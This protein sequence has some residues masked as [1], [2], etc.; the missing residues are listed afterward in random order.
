MLAIR[1]LREEKRASLL[2]T[3]IIVQAINFA[4]DKISA[5]VA[6]SDQSPS[7]DSLNKA[8]EELQDLFFP[9]QSSEREERAQRAKKIMEEE[10]KK[11]SFKV[12]GMVYNSPKRKR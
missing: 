3:N 2:Q 10:L 12:E 8:L 1:A 9:D 11:G 5:T 7:P 4:A 6:Q